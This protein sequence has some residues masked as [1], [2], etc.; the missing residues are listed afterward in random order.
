VTGVE[1]RKGIGSRLLGVISVILEER[2]LLFFGI[3]GV[4]LI[5]VGFI[6]GIRVL[7][8]LAENEILLTG[9]SLLA[10]LLL[11]VG[12]FS[13]FTGIILRTLLRRSGD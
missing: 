10:A 7:D 9:T 13:I 1:N 6:L 2:P 4:V 5:I 8:Y 12:V 11:G 3:C